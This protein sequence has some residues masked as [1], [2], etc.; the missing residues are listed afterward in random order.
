MKGPG[1]H[2]GYEL[3]AYEQRTFLTLGKVA[4]GKGRKAG[5]DF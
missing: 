5:V 2:K 1:V 4:L 3:A